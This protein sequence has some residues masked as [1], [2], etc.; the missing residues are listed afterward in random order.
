MTAD[1]L[2]LV[3]H[4]EVH[5]P[6]GILYGR[7]PGYHL[8]ELGTRM[9][10]AS[11]EWF[12]TTGRPVGRVISSPLERAIESA[13]PWADGAGVDIELSERI[14]E[15]SSRLEGGKYDVSLKILGVPKAWPYLV[16]PLRPS[17][18]EPFREVAAR[19][20]DELRDAWHGTEAGDVVLVSHQLPIW[21]AHR[22]GTGAPLVHD[23][24]KRR[25]AL[26]SITSF[27]FRGDRLVEVGY[28]DPAAGLGARAVDTGAV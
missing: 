10:R 12:A 27:E 20:V 7:L 23:P 28:A 26:S 6:T 1:R 21:M 3:R 16:N 25:C 14:I 19:V 4:G 17:W 18:G 5:N 9:A 15:A 22:V 2:H 13:Q 24:R 8:S 11:A